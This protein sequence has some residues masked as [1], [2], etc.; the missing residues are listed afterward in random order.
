MF[1]SVL[2]ACVGHVHF[3]VSI[4]PLLSGVSSAVGLNSAACLLLSVPTAAGR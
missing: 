2:S 4:S 1:S 3:P